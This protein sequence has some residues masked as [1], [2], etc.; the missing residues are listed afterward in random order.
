MATRA[1]GVEERERYQV[2]KNMLEDRRS[3]ILN[4]LRSLRE[5]RPDEIAQVRDAEEQSIDDFVQA[6]DF[7]VVQMKSETLRKIDEAIQRL[8][9]GTYGSCSECG[10]EITEARLKALP[11][12]DKCRDCQELAENRQDVELREA[13]DKETMFGKE[14]SSR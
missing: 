4:K 7:A 6:V 11:F 10:T 3:E 13:R 1:K 8:D 5:S 2:L 9:A 12:A 14:L